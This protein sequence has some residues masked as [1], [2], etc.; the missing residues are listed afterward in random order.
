MFTGT[1]GVLRGGPGAHYDRSLASGMAVSKGLRDKYPTRD[2]YIDKD[3]T[4][5]LEG[6]LTTLNKLLSHIDLFW[7][8]LH[9]TYGEDG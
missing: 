5:H 6:M 7:N 3:G 1:I 8:A 2:I 4:W 9:G